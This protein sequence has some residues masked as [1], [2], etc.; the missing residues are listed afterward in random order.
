MPFQL[1]L[2]CQAEAV[3]DTH[4]GYFICM[5]CLR[6][7]QL[8]SFEYDIFLGGAWEKYSS[9][10]YKKI[11]KSVF[12]DLKIYDPEDYS[13]EDWFAN[14]LEILKNSRSLLAMVPEFPFPLV[15]VE[16]GFYYAHHNLD[17]NSGSS[18]LVICW[19]N[20]V[21]PDWVKKNLFHLGEV[22]NSLAEAIMALFKFLY[23]DEIKQL[24]RQV[25]VES[26]AYDRHRLEP[27]SNF[28]SK[29]EIGLLGGVELQFE[30]TN[31]RQWTVSVTGQGK[32]STRN[33]EEVI[34]N[35]LEN[36]II[37]HLANEVI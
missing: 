21:K 12:T 1:S 6:P 4:Q 18:K 26:A 19:P 33:L 8:K 7:C 35:F 22:T 2:C 15:A 20:N 30:E 37:R 34:M 3:E 5:K 24:A 13:G 31:I 11:I 23:H 27:M 16:A 25:E 29:K 36:A 17:Q 32:I 28:F 10:P 14:N 9:L